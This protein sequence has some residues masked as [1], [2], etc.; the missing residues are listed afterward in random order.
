MPNILIPHGMVKLFIL[1]Y[2]YN[3]P[4]DLNK[5]ECR[6]LKLKAMKYVLID[7][8]LYWS[9]HGGMLLKCFQRS[10]VDS[11]TAELHGDARGG[12]KYWKATT[13]KILR[14]CY[15]WPTLFTYVYT[16]VKACLECQKFCW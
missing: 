11:V 4:H 12:H 14:A 5:N 6:S 1:D 9:N 16:Q 8:I 13:F 7:Q 3:V 10:E 15:Y 2:I